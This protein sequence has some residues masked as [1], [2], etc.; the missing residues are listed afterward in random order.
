MP[1]PI[2]KS[3]RAAEKLIKSNDIPLDDNLTFLFYFHVDNSYMLFKANEKAWPKTILNSEKIS[4][5]RHA[6]IDFP[7]IGEGVFQ[8]KGEE[9]VMEALGKYLQSADPDRSISDLDL[10]TKVKEIFMG[11][12]SV[13]SGN[14]RKSVEIEAE[15]YDQISDSDDSTASNPSPELD[16]APKKVKLS[17]KESNR[18]R[19][20][21][22]NCGSSESDGSDKSVSDQLVCEKVLHVLSRIEQRLDRSNNVQKDILMFA[23]KAMKEVECIQDATKEKPD[24]ESNESLD[25][26]FYKDT[27]L[28]DLGGDTAEEKLKRI[29]RRLWTKSE[30]SK[31][32]IDPQ[33][34]L[35]P[36]ATGRDRADEDR[37]AA[38]KKAAKV[39]LGSQ[40]SQK[41]YKRCVRLIN[42]MG[43]GYKNRGFLESDSD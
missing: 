14:K 39:V 31:I 4:L 30:L 37:E 15:E 41:L 27:C 40:Y 25:K 5:Q 18:G 2:R 9:I 16:A 24:E 36:E 13:N 23:K 10:S 3:D 29:A 20:K 34:S 32:V 1:T 28:T 35:K 8:A 42:V 17:Q 21:C 7:K 6:K 26:V 22:T 33:K 43:N 19:E 12:S 11:L 38:F